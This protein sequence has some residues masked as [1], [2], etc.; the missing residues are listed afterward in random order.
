MFRKLNFWIV[1]GADILLLAA[2]HLLAYGIRFEFVLSLREWAQIWAV[3]PWLLPL[4]VVIFFFFGL[5][6]GM[7][8]YTGVTDLLNI[9]RA[10]IATGL[11]VMAVLLL[12]TRFEGFSRS[13]F[14]LDTILTFL[15]V[16]GIRFSLRLFYQALPT[17]RDLETKAVRRKRLL[18]V[19]AGD[20]AEK[21][22]REIMDNRALPYQVV[23]FLDD[24]SAKIG[25]RIH[26]I[27]VLGP[28]ADVRGQVW[29]SKAQEILIAIPTANRD[30]MSRIVDFCRGA[31]VP[32]KT[33]PGLGELISDKVSI[34]A[35]RDVSY[36]DLLGRKP[37]RLE[38]AKIDDILASR[39][40]LVTGAGGSIGSELCRQILR[41]NPGKLILFDAG[42]EN[43][44]RIEMEVLHERGFR[45]YVTVLGKV[46]DRGLLTH[47][48]EH[49]RPEVVFHAAA[50]KHVPL[51]EANPWEGVYNNIFASKRLMEVALQ[52]GVDRFILVSTD[53]AVRPPNVMGAS[54]RLTEIL[55]QAYCGEPGGNTRFMAVRFGNVLGSSGSVIPLFKRQIE[56]GG[57][58]TVTHPEMTR[59]FM[60]IEEA[61]Q[62]ILQAAAMG[63]GGEIFILEMGTP[64]R[65]GQM[66]HD[67]IRLCGKEPEAEIEIKYIG[68]RPGEKMHEELITEGEG[69]VP[70][71]HEKIM[72]LRGRDASLADLREPLER[73][74]E[75]A[76]R[77][78]AAGIKAELHKVIPEYTPRDTTSILS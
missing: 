37:V 48:F 28:I 6:R 12:V 61:S 67:L 11:L 39:T 30:Q 43:L 33:L 77:H 23:G 26:G 75:C 8:R 3:L 73:L 71:D 55:M 31:G 29:R 34:K 44:Y 10:S 7:W 47:V 66:A 49:Y 17:F 16:A 27:P 38:L 5:Y 4:K 25:Q 40:V 24:N 53:K 20:A 52:Y 2:A 54:K 65:I 32:F 13:V 42:E 69:I 57:P 50:Y 64:V 18:L 56:M 51:V 35:I 1:L 9:L 74:K 14:V 19:G 45:D 76:R 22:V 41:F 60:S 63:E 59:Y 68:L 72:V 78:D 62:L 36:K 21:I 70:T 46:Q 58:V 15:F